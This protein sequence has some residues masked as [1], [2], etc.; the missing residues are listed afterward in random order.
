MYNQLSP[1]LL[2][3]M[4]LTLSPGPDVL[5]VLIKSLQSG[6]KAGIVLSLGL[7]SGI[8]MHTLLVAS[9]VSAVILASENL[10]F[11]IK[12][13]G[14]SYLLYLSWLV[15]RQPAQINLDTNAPQ[16]GA[17]ALFR[18][19]FFMN[20]LNPK[21]S[22]FFLA[23]FPGFLWNTTG[24]KFLQIGFLGVVFMLQAFILFSLIAVFAGKI[25]KYL[26]NN[27]V[28]IFFKYLQIALF[29]AIAVY[30]LL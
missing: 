10:F 24:N 21:V 12:L 15:F 2:A 11:G 16:E 26:K 25:S 14:V 19:G 17:S 3:S 1:F 13:F 18:R 9:G 7:V 6:Q 22:I 20:V 30:L 27:R 23:F 4:L 28:A 8:I 29:L 5:Y